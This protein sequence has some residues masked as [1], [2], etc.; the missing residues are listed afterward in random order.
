MAAIVAKNTLAKYA[1]KVSPRVE[2]I[3]GNNGHTKVKRIFGD[4]RRTSSFSLAPDLARRRN[5]PKVGGT[6]PRA[7]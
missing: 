4:N 1:R 2:V 7:G 3:T 6:V 5:P